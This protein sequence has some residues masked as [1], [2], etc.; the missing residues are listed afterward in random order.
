VLHH[1]PARV[2]RQPLRRFRGNARAVFEDRLTRRIN[3]GQYRR[4]D[5]DDHLITLARRAGVEIVMQGRLREQG[6]CI[7]LLLRHHRRFRGNVERRI[8]GLLAALLV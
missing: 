7:G 6:Q 1:H 3:I 4:V 5:V 8:E 2:A